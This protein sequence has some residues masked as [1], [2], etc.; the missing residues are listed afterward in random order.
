M[1]Y[2][3]TSLLNEAA[4][5]LPAPVPVWLQVAEAVKLG[6]GYPY[7]AFYTESEAI[8]VDPPSGRT[9]DV[10]EDPEEGLYARFDHEIDPNGG[11]PFPYDADNLSA[12]VQDAAEYLMGLDLGEYDD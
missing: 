9:V 12:L 2:D 8:L 7:E 11:E 1:Q 5:R 3:H 6:W 4:E 10:G